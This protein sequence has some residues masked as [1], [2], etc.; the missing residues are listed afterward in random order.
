MRALITGGAGFFG[1]ILRTCL[2]AA[3]S[4]CVSV[5]LEPDPFKHRNSV[6]SRA[7]IRDRSALA[8]VF[9]DYR[10]D[11]VYHCA[12]ILAHDAKDRGFLWSSNVDGTHTVAE[13]AV[14]YRVPKVVFTSSNCLWADPFNRPVTESDEPRPREIYGQ[15]KWEGEKILQEHAGPYELAIIRTPTIIDAGRLGLLS[16]LFE[17][18][19]EGRRVWV[20]GG[21]ENKYQFVYARDLADACM[22]A[23]RIGA[24][25]VFNVGSDHVAPLR[26]V[27]QSVI[28]RARSGATI[29]SLPRFPTLE[30]MRLA[31]T[32]GLSPLGPY[33]YRMIAESFE[34]DTT[35]ARTV[36]G[37][38][39][40]LTN[41]DMLWR[42]FEYYRDHRREIE[43][44]TDVSAHSR[45]AR[46]GAIRLLKWI[47]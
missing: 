36:L 33:Q 22:R 44:R 18:I 19:A 23:A 31:H 20:V 4:M 5:D 13:L 46:M 27:Y 25:G 12:A 38:T 7:D 47:S 15:S 14:Q 34:F 8:K 1:Q 45:P 30:V 16:I 26:D 24:S 21:G 11:C 40:T 28:N 35:R 37:W 42:A 3:G 39:P 6:S 29:V 10:F 9:G 43:S 32:L 17:F 41:A 2:L